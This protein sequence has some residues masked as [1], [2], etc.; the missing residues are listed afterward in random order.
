MGEKKIM[1][2]VE[3][4]YQT[5]L[6]SIKKEMTYP[7]TMI[8]WIILGS[9]EIFIYYY[10]WK[11]IYNEQNMFFGI[12][13]EQIITYIILSRILYQLFSWGAN[14]EI[15]KT[16]KDG[17][18]SIELLKPVNYQSM[19]YA[20]RIG[21]FILDV[22]LLGVPLLIISIFSFGMLYPTSALHFLLFCVSIF[23]AMTVAFLIEYI[24][25]TITF[26]TVS[27]WGIQ[28]L[29]QALIAFFSGA[30]IPLQMLPSWLQK[31]TDLLPFKSM[32]YFPVSIYLGN[33]TF[34]QIFS[35]FMIQL[36]WIAI[37]CYIS[38]GLFK[39]AL[40]KV[41]IAGG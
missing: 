2:S 20:F 19:Q 9:I 38:G 33:I 35:G 37:L 5:I 7:I 13:Y 11:A 34:E 23:L 36:I 32:I 21:I 22:V 4:I 8:G 6:I 10:I 25:A 24:A 41:V 18:I 15:S 31:I 29:K 30:L 17:N 1:K 40:K 27:S 28:C 39:I 16:I 14:A 3:K 12:T 26:Y